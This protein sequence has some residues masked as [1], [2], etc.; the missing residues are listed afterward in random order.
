MKPKSRGTTLTTVAD[1]VVAGERSVEP[2]QAPRVLV[3]RGYR[4]VPARPGWAGSAPA[5]VG[6]VAEPV[7]PYVL[8][9]GPGKPGGRGRGNE[10][11]PAAPHWCRPDL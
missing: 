2:E 9:R 6:G 10:R 1:V 8:T 4:R 3:E 5:L 11:S 7:R